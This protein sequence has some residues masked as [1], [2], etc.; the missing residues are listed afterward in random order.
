MGIRSGGLFELGHLRQAR[1]A[2]NAALDAARARGIP[3]HVGLFDAILTLGALSLE[4]GQLD[5][6]ERLIEEAVRC[7]E[8][9][10]PPFELLGLIERAR[11]FRARGELVESL[12]ILERAST[13]LPAGSRSPLNQRADVLEARIRMDLGDPGRAADLART[14]P[15]SPNRCL[16][17]ARAWLIRG[18][19][20]RA[21]VTMSELDAGA[22]GVSLAIQL[23]A[24]RADVRRHLGLCYDDDLRRLVELARPQAFVLSVLDGSPGLRDDL[25][26][27]LR[28]SP[29]DDYADTLVTAADRIAAHGEIGP[30]YK[31]SRLSAREQGVLRFLP[32]RLSTREIAGELF[33]SM[34]TLKTHLKSIYRKLDA[35]SRSDAVAR[36]RASGLL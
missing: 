32:T 21:D 8:R 16:L 1:T 27:L 35:S 28:H 23:T 19:A 15:P 22:L 17:E 25:V 13:V 30:L 7:S 11:L 4:A 24:L 36:A 6:A 10:R 5:E 3:N 34:N 33:I 18:Q 12:G 26:T 31:D 20:D 9:I 14:L 2:A 29:G